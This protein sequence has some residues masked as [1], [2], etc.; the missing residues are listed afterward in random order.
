[1]IGVRLSRLGYKS[2]RVISA[3]APP[4]ASV[5]AQREAECGPRQHA[6]PNILYFPGLLPGVHRKG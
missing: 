4:E 2:T 1:L 6:G 5:R 3:D